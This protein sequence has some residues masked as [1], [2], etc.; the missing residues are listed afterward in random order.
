MLVEFYRFNK[1]V[2]RKAIF[3]IPGLCFFNPKP[4]NTWVFTRDVMIT[5]FDGRGP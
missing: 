4:N 1:A 2:N 5:R 3:P